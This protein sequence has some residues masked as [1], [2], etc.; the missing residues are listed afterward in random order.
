VSLTGDEAS[1]SDAY[2]L[3]PTELKCGL[4]VEPALISVTADGD[5]RAVLSNPTG[6]SM[7]LEEGS[8][9][10]EAI[11]ATPI[12]SPANT[13]PPSEPIPQPALRWVQSK[14]TSW[15]KKKL[16]E[17]VGSLGALPTPQRE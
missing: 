1:A 11:P 14:S 6:T 12:P 8:S 7:V 16:A 9:L 5:V 4:V 15:R 13:G 17:T 3:E 2:I 10:G